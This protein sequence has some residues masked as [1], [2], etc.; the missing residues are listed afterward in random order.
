MSPSD[1]SRLL[2][3]LLLLWAVS[4]LIGWLTCTR[5]M[6]ERDEARAELHMQSPTPAP[7]E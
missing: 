5:V 3:S 6:R 1:T 2:L 7:H 4:I